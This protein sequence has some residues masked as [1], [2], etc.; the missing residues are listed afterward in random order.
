MS[1]TTNHNSRQLE[2]TSELLEE[3]YE[4]YNRPEF[5]HPDPL[6]FVLRYDDPAN[7][8]IVGLVA[9]A[10]A[11]GKV[12][13]I[14]K[15]LEKVFRLLPDPAGDLDGASKKELRELLY[16]FRHRWTTGEEL[17][18]LLLGIRL[19]REQ[20]GS[21]EACF[22][23]GMQEDHEN[24]LPALQA[25]VAE[26]RSASGRRDSSLLACP[27]RGSA[28]KRSLLYLRWMVRRDDVDPGPWTTVDPGKLVIPMDT[29]MHRIATELGLTDRKQADMK[30]ALSVTGFFRELV[31]ED[32]VRYDFTLTRFGINPELDP[33]EINAY[34]P[35]EAVRS[36][37]I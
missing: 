18:D 26:L 8:E 29:H 13:H 7:Q 35:S 23:S 22:T 14:L 30:A 34:L 25:F 11:Y 27:S 16:G 3:L 28:C 17:A 24:I 6:E 19:V 36:A 12:S 1:N 20:W 32:P 31:P 10:L 21:L 33:K 4:R 9:S 37:T 5:I 15:S 2:L